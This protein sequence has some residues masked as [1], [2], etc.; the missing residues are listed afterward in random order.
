MDSATIPACEAMQPFLGGA[1][2]LA[3]SLVKLLQTAFKEVDTDR[4][5]AKAFIAKASSLLQSRS[6]PSG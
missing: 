3:G 6:E 1:G 2:E 4:E 5:A